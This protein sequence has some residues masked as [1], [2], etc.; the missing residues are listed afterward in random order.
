MIQKEINKIKYIAEQYLE[1]PFGSIDG[2]KRTRDV[3]L[4]RMV[5]GAF[6]VCDLNISIGK[7][8]KLLNRDRTSFYF[9]QKKYKEYMSDCKIYPE[10]IELY[11]FIHDTYMNDQKSLLKDANTKNWL[12]KLETVKNH[13][14]II[15][16]KMKQIEE[17]AKMLGI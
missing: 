12:Y 1:I 4:A 5:V 11:N 3:S 13:Q 16:R 7:A 14:K 6:I 17:E 15:D 10:Y 2:E 9:Y 8:C